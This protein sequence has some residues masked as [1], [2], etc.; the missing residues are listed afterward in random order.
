MSVKAKKAENQQMEV[1]KS[2]GMMMTVFFAILSLAFLFPI[3]LV[4][5]NSFKSKLYIR[6]FSGVWKVSVYYGLLRSSNCTV[7]LHDGMVHYQSE[8]E[9]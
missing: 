7:Y 1:S 2:T 9:I 5:V 6:I 4:L 8:I 3:F